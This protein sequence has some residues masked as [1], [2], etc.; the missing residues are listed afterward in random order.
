[1]R[2]PCDEDKRGTLSLSYG[3]LWREEVVVGKRFFLEAHGV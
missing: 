3:R 2:S 1:M